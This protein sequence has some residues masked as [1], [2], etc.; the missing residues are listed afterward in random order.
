MLERLQKIM[1]CIYSFVKTMPIGKFGWQS[2]DQLHNQSWSSQFPPST[3][4][5]GHFLLQSCVIRISGLS[6]IS[7]NCVY[8]TKYP[9]RQISSPLVLSGY[10]DRYTE[11]TAGV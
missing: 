6:P 11:T 1:V 4:T 7:A 5:S 8:I 10:H 9:E 2:Q 3:I